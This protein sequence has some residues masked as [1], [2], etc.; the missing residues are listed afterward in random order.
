MAKKEYVKITPEGLN[1]LTIMNYSHL[2]EGGTGFYNRTV[3]FTDNF[4]AICSTSVRRSEISAL[5]RARTIWIR[6]F[7]TSLFQT[8][9]LNPFRAQKPS[10]FWS[11]CKT[12]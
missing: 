6:T 2:T 1:L 3:F 4:K 8:V 10:I 11:T 12:A 9:L 7:H 5:F